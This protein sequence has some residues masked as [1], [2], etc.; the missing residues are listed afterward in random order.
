MLL[1]F[2]IT[3]VNLNILLFTSS[4]IAL[5]KSS[6]SLVLDSGAVHLLFLKQLVNS[7][8]A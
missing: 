7:R 2:S 8:A 6:F 4:T 3:F 5:L 1:Q